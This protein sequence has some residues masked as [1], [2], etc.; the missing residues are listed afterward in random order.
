MAPI[1]PSKRNFVYSKWHVDHAV[2]VYRAVIGLI[3]N[4]LQGPSK[5]PGQVPGNG[6]EM[7]LYGRFRPRLPWCHPIFGRM[8]TIVASPQ[9]PSKYLLEELVWCLRCNGQMQPATRLD[10]SRYYSCG[11]SCEQ[12]DQPAIQLEQDLLLRALVRAHH[13]LFG[14]G[15]QAIDYPKAAAARPSPAATSAAPWQQPGQLV[16][17]RAEL[18]RWQYCDITDRR[19]VLRVAFVCVTI[20]AQGAVRVVWRHEQE[21]L[22]H[23]KLAQA[24]PC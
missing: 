13:A 21:A 3:Q 6:T 8:V 11:V 4:A 1:I 15:R 17:T 5:A 12:P 19:A 10:G 18:R 14:V 7:A 16:V 22:T 23:R 2:L 9:P 24:T 20:D